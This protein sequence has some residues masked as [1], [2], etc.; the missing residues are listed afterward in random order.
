MSTGWSGEATCAPQPADVPSERVQEDARAHVR[1]VVEGSGSSFFW[2][3]R[4]LPRPKREA[5]FAIYAFC[6]EIDDIADGAASE[7]EKRRA[8]DAWRHEIDNL[9]RRRPQRPT[10]RALLEPVA[11]YRLPMAEF[12]ALI[13]GM[14]MDAGPPIQA[15]SLARLEH[16]C[17]CVAG[18]VG[19][20]S[21]RVFGARSARADE[22]AVALGEALQLT[23]ILRDLVEDGARGRLYLPRELLDRAGIES[24]APSAVLGAP[25]LPQACEALLDRAGQRFVEARAW[26]DDERRRQVRPA[27][28]MMHVYKAQFERLRARGF[29]DLSQPVRLSRPEKLWLAIRYGF[30]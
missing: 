14:A 12:H 13:E 4:L 19:L 22:G 26:L 15:P 27:V 9:Y 23:N 17:R 8:L 11:R 1:R 29:E 16:Y 21:V 28:I 20:L 5:M 18:A 30:L 6:R 24:R 3:M 25:T 10:A 2:S 7:D